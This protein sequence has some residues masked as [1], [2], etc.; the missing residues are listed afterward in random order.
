MRRVFVPDDA[1]RERSD[2]GDDHPLAC[3]NAFVLKGSV[4][5]PFVSRKL[6]NVSPIESSVD[7]RIVL[8]A[9][10]RSSIS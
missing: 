10:H 1:S 9:A 3:A 7:N 5:T 2:T 6:D 8:E 4:S